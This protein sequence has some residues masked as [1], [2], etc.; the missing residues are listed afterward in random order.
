METFCW[1]RFFIKLSNFRTGG[2]HCP[3][4][5]LPQHTLLAHLGPLSIPT[6]LSRWCNLTRNDRRSW[7]LW[8][9]ACSHGNLDSFAMKVLEGKSWVSPLP[10]EVASIVATPERGWRTEK[11]ASESLSGR[12]ETKAKS[13]QAHVALRQPCVPI[14]CSCTW[15]FSPKACMSLESRDTSTL[16]WNPALHLVQC[17]IPG[18]CLVNVC[19]GLLIEDVS[20]PRSPLYDQLWPL[21]TQSHSYRRCRDMS[22]TCI[23]PWSAIWKLHYCIRK[24][25]FWQPVF[26]S[27]GS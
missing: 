19:W 15:S 1:E 20:M 23:N 24:K 3:V 2:D 17:L 13:L 26:L 16:Y 22:R 9:K 21:I 27:L 7:E 4:Q 11:M 6:M 8:G 18:S 5:A 12:A 25:N 10:M 14:T